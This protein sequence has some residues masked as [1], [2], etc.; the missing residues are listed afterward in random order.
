MNEVIP[1]GWEKMN[2]DNSFR[3]RMPIPKFGET[4]IIK[5]R[6]LSYLI[7][8]RSIEKEERLMKVMGD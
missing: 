7:K 3:E 6:K 1:R 5:L 8:L 4:L 2:S